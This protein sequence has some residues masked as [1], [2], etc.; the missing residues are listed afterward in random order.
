ML[1]RKQH[2]FREG[3]TYRP[4]HLYLGVNAF[5]YLNTCIDISEYVCIYLFMRVSI[6]GMLGYIDSDSRKFKDEVI[7][8]E[9]S[10]DQNTM[11][12]CLRPDS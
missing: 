12:I 6:L 10:K 5:I 2:T 7:P 11:L 1:Q 9:I 4:I 3:K 8:R